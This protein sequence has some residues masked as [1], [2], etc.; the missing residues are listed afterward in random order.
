MTGISF[1]EGLSLFLVNRIKE[2][3]KSYYLIRALNSM[4]GIFYG[5]EIL[6]TLLVKKMVVKDVRGQLSFYYLTQM[7]ADLLKV[8]ETQ[9]IETMIRDYSAKQPE[10]IEAL[11]KIN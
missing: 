1:E 8:N 7:G 11:L 5:N 10:Y 2:Y 6:K 3:K 4:F 9:I